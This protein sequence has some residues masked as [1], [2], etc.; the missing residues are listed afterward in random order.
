M[1]GLP[2]GRSVVLLAFPGVQALD[3]VGPMEVFT[4]A[5]RIVDGAYDVR[6]AAPGHGGLGTSSGLMLLPTGSLPDMPARIDT[7][8]VCGGPDVGAAERDERLIGWLRDA[9][10]RSRRVSS[11]CS[12]ALLLARAGLLDGRRAT[13]HW[14]ACR[15]LAERYPQVTVERDAIFVRDGQVWTSAGVTA[16]MDLA[17]ALV[18]EDLGRD[19]ALEI[20]RWLVLFVKRP[21]G[22]SQFSSRIA[23]QR[24]RTGSLR[25]VTDWI[26]RNLVADLRIE[27][28]ADRVCMSPRNFSRAFRRETGTT[29]AKYVEI[30][31][32]QAALQALADAADG[33][34]TVAARCGFGTA[35]TMRRAFH[36]HLGIGPAEYRTRFSS[37]LEPAVQDRTTRET[38]EDRIPTL[39]GIHRNYD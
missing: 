13:T 38:H 5:S 17:L 26:G 10:G 18:E 27:A 7:L 23:G 22:Q 36:R 32:V 39:Q 30:T 25:D 20:A 16:G 4:G 6:V 1:N 28:L 3:L 35:E 24:P 37:A 31:R 11:V 34:D 19:V 29:P 12:G 14:A 8:V 9:A 21:G 2:C 33:V 15:E